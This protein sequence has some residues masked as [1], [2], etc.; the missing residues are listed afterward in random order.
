MTET[1]KET[2]TKQNSK[3]IAK[4]F[5]GF[6]VQSLTTKG[7]ADFLNDALRLAIGLMLLFEYPP[8][9]TRDPF[10]QWIGAIVV[11]FLAFYIV[12]PSLIRI[13]WGS[14]E[15]W[16]DAIEESTGIGGDPDT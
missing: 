12:L 4:R 10:L 9:A 1:E 5:W 6:R 2:Q 3:T 14:Y 8:T 13:L 15:H 11:I 7:I 16:V